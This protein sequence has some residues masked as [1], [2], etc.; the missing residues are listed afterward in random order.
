MA[1]ITH[2]QYMEAKDVLLPDIIAAVR[3]RHTA[4][5]ALADFDE[6]KAAKFVIFTLSY[7]VACVAA[8]STPTQERYEAL[9]ELIIDLEML[10][11]IREVIL[12]DPIAEIS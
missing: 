3:R 8:H 7:A 1:T 12:E 4:L 9:L 6:S 11:S 10:K 5:A 2:Q